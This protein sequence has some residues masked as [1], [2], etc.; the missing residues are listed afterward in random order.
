MTHENYNKMFP[1]P[2]TTRAEESSFRESFFLGGI[3]AYHMNIMLFSQLH[4]IL[5]SQDADLITESGS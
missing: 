1:L 4:K 5:S 2:L 3:A